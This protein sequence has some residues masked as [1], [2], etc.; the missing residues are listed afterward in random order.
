[1]YKCVHLYMV[2][3]LNFGIVFRDKC[4]S[5][6]KFESLYCKVNKPSI[7]FV[8]LFLHIFFLFPSRKKHFYKYK[9]QLRL[10]KSSFI[11]F[12][13]RFLSSLDFVYSGQIQSFRHKFSYLTV[14]CPQLSSRVEDARAPWNWFWDSLRLRGGAAQSRR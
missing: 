8:I 7:I 5:C 2:S 12:P 14:L 13:L 11:W 9:I 10:S 4:V 3:D 6:I 1:M